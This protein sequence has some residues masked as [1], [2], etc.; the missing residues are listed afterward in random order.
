VQLRSYLG[1]NCSLNG[2]Y[3]SVVEKCR[4]DLVSSGMLCP[5][6]QKTLNGVG[7]IDACLSDLPSSCWIGILVVFW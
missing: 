3:L 6:R 1:E 4:K 7:D 2:D 5:R